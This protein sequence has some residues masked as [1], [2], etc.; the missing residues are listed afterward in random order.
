ENSI[1]P[2]QPA[3]LSFPQL[4]CKFALA[5][6]FHSQ[7]RLIC[8]PIAE[9]AIRTVSV[10]SVCPVKVRLPSRASKSYRN[11]I[12]IEFVCAVFTFCD[13]CPSLAP[14]FFPLPSPPQEIVD[15]SIT[16]T[17]LPIPPRAGPACGAA[18]SPGIVIVPPALEN[19]AD[20]SRIGQPLTFAAPVK[21]C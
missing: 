5:C 19:A 14:R 15:G 4:R 6:P 18:A 20:S 17:F 3:V 9:A 12:A 2:F 8:L 7:P 1:C 13:P 16:K 11:P 21:Y 10:L